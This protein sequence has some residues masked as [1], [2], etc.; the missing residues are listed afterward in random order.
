MIF[1]EIVMVVPRL[2]FTV[3]DLDKSNAAFEEAAGDQQLP[4]LCA[5]AIQVADVLGL[6]SDVERVRGVNLH[7]VGQ[8]ERLDTSFELAVPSAAAGMLLV[9]GVEQVKL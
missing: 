5:C 9:Q 1:F 6:F 4:G 8:F 3:P 2:T 7:A